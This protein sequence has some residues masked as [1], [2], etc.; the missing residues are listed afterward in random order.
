MNNC[1]EI[2][3]ISNT[4]DVTINLPS[5]KSI[6][7]RALILNALSYSPYDIKNLSDS[8]DTQVM[9]K[10]LDSNDNK[11]DIGAAGTAMRFLTAFL[12]KTVGKWEITGSQRMQQRPIKI[13]V[14]AL[15]QLG[16]KIEY[17]GKEGFPPLQIFGSGLTGGKLELDGSVSSQYISALMMIAP[18]MQNGLTLKL[19]GDVI[20][21]PYIDMTKKMMQD[22]G[23]KV[24]FSDNTI[25]I[26]PQTYTPLSYTIE[27]DWSAASYWYEILSLAGKGKVFL[28]GL[29]KNSYQGDRAIVDIF[30]KIGIKTTF[31]ED[32]ILISLIPTFGQ[33]TET[34]R[35]DFT[36]TP[37][38]AQTLV[39]TCC[40]K[41]IHFEFSG[42]Q[43]LRIK[44]TDRISALQTELKK[45]G[46]ILETKNHDKLI[47]NG[48]KCEKTPNPTIETYEDHR[49]AMAFAPIGLIE[50]ITIANP[51]V[52]SKS[53]PAF[54]GDFDSIFL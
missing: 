3:P 26:L 53:Y 51:K 43:S 8:D 18:Y 49:M 12:A 4:I 30:H 7:N 27:S 19:K 40:M 32:G 38:L 6:S 1:K 2:V 50:P 54:W 47:W 16:G 11:F 35:H 37:D 41:N 14:D 9:L 33:T 44:E 31:Q 5:S 15:N 39:V 28:H 48:S 22:F 10:V 36:E 34:F 13:L 42:L 23:V 25:S 17:L 46:F 52:V 21:K 45:L 29:N 20:S 24:E